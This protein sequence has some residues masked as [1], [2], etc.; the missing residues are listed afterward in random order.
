M[1]ARRPFFVMG[2][3]LAEAH[4]KERR[5]QREISRHDRLYGFGTIDLNRRDVRD[6]VKRIHDLGL[7]GI[8]MHPNAQQFDILSPL[9]N[10]GFA[11]TPHSGQPA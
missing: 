3:D 4:E 5:L 10:G 2:A 11:G 7:K 6:Q 1:G 8:K 9:Q